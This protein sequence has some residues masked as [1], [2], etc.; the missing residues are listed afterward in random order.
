MYRVRAHKR[1]EGG[2]GE[3]NKAGREKVAGCRGIRAKESLLIHPGKGWLEGVGGT[4][5]SDHA[6]KLSVAGRRNRIASEGKGEVDK[7]AAVR[8]GG[9]RE[10]K[11][12]CKRARSGRELY[13]ACVCTD[14]AVRIKD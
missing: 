3:H 9:G 10:R 11:R 13:I 1:E 8:V 6:E 12:R 5:L 2:G 7:V 14:R 4:T